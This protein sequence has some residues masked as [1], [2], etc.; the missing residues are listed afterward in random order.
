[1]I[2]AIEGGSDWA[3]ASVEYLWV[4]KD[5]NYDEAKKLYFE[6]IHT[7]SN[8]WIDFCKWLLNNGFATLPDD[9]DLI[10]GTSD[11]DY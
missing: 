4:Q 1:M 3:D 6:F 8:K 9:K 11:L 7:P 2:L 5:F 10:V